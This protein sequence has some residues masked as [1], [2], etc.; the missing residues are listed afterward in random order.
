M[1][2]HQFMNFKS[3]HELDQPVYRIM[4]QEH[5]FSLFRESRNV[6]SK[7]SNWKDK[8]ENFLMHCG[9]EI[10][11]VTGE[12]NRVLTVTAAFA[13]FSPTRNY[14][15]RHF[16]GLCRKARHVFKCLTLV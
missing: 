9:H 3:V 16:R 8:F 1:Q 12:P 4:K 11:G 14:L 13:L 6:M 15:N 2:E 7:F 10:D 5:V